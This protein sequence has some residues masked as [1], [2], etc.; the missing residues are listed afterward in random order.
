MET[1]AA[2]AFDPVDAAFLTDPY[3]ELARLR[4]SARVFRDE[5]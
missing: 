5:G 1:S 4:E 3:P 2:L